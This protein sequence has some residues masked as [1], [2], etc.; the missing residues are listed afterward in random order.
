MDPSLNGLGMGITVLDHRVIGLGLVSIMII[1]SGFDNY[2]TRP[3]SNPLTCLA[4]GLQS[5][6]RGKNKSQ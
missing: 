2:C 6:A 5:I 4:C 3:E 1:G